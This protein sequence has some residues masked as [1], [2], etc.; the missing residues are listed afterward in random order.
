MTVLVA[1]TAVNIAEAWY[2]GFL[3]TGALAGITGLSFIALG[4]VVWRVRH[5]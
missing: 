3:G 5:Q 2:V 4:V 1:Q